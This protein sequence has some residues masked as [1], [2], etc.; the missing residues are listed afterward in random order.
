MANG[1]LDINALSQS[2][3]SFLHQTVMHN[4]PDCYLALLENEKILCEI[5]PK[6]ECHEINSA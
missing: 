2:L 3:N 1:G 6:D 4:L 5:A